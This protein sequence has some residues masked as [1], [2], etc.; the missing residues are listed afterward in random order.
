MRAT[1]RQRT[2]HSRL[3]PIMNCNHVINHLDDYLDGTLP[4]L[5][6]GP[7]GAHLDSCPACSREL[8]ELSAL[9][10][11]L[12]RLPSPEGTPQVLERLLAAAMRSPGPAGR[13]SYRPVVWHRAG[14]ATAAAL[15]LAVGFGL[16][17]KVTGHK[18]F[19]GGLQVVAAAQPI[20]V[21][22]AAEPVAL[23]FRTSDALHDASISVRLPDDVQI[24]GRPHVRQLSWHADLKAGANLLELPLQ[25]VG[26][27]GG[28]LVVQLSQGSLMKTLRIPITV[29]TAREPATGMRPVHATPAMT[30]VT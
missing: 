4:P 22:P 24:A 21:G 29:R 12:A 18:S 27:R 19:E 5:Q 2:Y 26:P 30:S 25:S 20:M 10:S 6:A 3:G 16:G 1:P 7:V 8:R 14:I 15:L 28:T 11:A 23:M 13:A 17:L 9:R